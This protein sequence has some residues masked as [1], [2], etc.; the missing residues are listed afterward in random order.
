MWLELQIV[1]CHQCLVLH[2][3]ADHASGCSQ[4][5]FEIPLAELLQPHG[6]QLAQAAPQPVC[7]LQ[8]APLPA[9]LVLLPTVALQFIFYAPNP[10]D[11]NAGWQYLI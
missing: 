11:G 4:T 6:I 7:L 5:T 9:R 8:L 2:P 1:S 3:P 10:R